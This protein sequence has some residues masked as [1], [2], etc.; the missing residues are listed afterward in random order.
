M[1]A[2][3]FWVGLI[4]AVVTSLLTVFGPGTR[5]YQV[6]TVVSALVTAA[7]V[8]LV[9]NAPAITPPADGRVRRSY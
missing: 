6:L 3:K 7:G 8:Y 4:G 1:K 9:P 2:A 5:T